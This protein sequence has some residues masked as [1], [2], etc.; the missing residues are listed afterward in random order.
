MEFINFDSVD[1]AGYLHQIPD[2]TQNSLPFGLI[3]VDLKGKILEYNM[4]EG[5]MMGVDPGWAIGKNFFDDVASCTKPEAFYGRFAEGVKKGFLNTV[6]EYTF[7]HRGVAT[8]VK[9]TMVTM[10]DHQGQKTVVIMIKRTSKPQIVDAF[11]PPAL[12]SA[13]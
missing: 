11:L 4:A 5:E 2:A 13:G 6:F 7:H 3:R 9:V 12:P 1:L 8:G 10:P